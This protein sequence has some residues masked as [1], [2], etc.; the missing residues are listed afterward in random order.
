MAKKVRKIRTP[1]AYGKTHGKIKS[2]QAKQ[3]KK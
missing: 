1:K 2:R 3:R